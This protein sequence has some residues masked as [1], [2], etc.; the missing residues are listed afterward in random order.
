[1][2][3]SQFQILPAIK[4]LADFHVFDAVPLEGSITVNDLAAAVKLNATFLG[5]HKM[6]ALSSALHT[7]YTYL[8]D[9]FL[10][11]VLTQGIFNETTTGAYEHTAASKTFRTDQAASF[12]NLG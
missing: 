8:L 10:R 4:V 6:R 12:Y 11:I 1:M 7:A 9:R 3:P 5:S 2:M